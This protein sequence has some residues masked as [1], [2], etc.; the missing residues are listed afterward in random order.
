MGRGVHGGAHQPCT[1]HVMTPASTSIPLTIM[2][3]PVRYHARD[4]SPPVSRLHTC[5]VARVARIWKSTSLSTVA[6]CDTKGACMEKVHGAVSR[7]RD[8]SCE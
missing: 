7:R 2:K 4:S 8:W 3:P 6:T 5:A 1:M